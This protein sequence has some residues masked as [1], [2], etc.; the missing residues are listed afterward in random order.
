[1]TK[2]APFAIILF[3]A[4]VLFDH[5]Y[6]ENVGDYS[7][8]PQP[9]DNFLEADFRLV[10][11][12]DHAPPSAILVFIPGTDGDGRGIIT[13]STFLALSKACHAALMGCDYRGEGLSYEDPTGGSGRAL[14]EAISHFAV[15]THTPELAQAPLLL[16]GYSQGGIFTYNY[17]C[18][19]PERVR[20]FAALKAVIPKFQP[21]PES[22]RIPG[23]LIA[24]QMD[25]PERIRSISSAFAAAAGKHSEWALLFERGNGHELDQKSIGLT[26]TFFE[27]IFQP[28]KAVRPIFLNAESGISETAD[29]T[30]PG[31]CWFPNEDVAESWR[32]LHQPTSLS[33]L[34]TIPEWPQLQ[35]LISVKCD[36]E[37]YGCENGNQQLGILDL[38][39][40]TAGITIDHV[41]AFG[42]GFSV[43]STETDKLPMQIKLCFAPRQL[44]WGQI[45]A[46]IELDGSLSGKKLQPFSFSV[47]G[48]VKGPVTAIPSM[49]YLGIVSRGSN[50]AQK[51]LLKSSLSS[52]HIADIRT[53]EGMT[54]TVE[55]KG[56][57]DTQLEVHWLVG[58]RLGR[59]NAEIQLTLDSPEKGTLRIPVI[60]IVSR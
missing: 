20:A 44:P 38:I 29:S 47:L 31:V 19:Y 40:D 11:P 33:D 2:V 10:F 8:E 23:L 59:M 55:E 34:M 3:F 41:Q 18:S 26:Q 28:S 17:V 57:G 7:V 50:I 16:I 37:K 27:A 32:H 15:S 42:E 21:K 4:T 49:I 58:S 53:P 1:M 54:V 14:D 60:G 46:D 13:N 36:P 43:V 30:G 5:V 45:R 6:S 48:V 56:D 9:K 12:D 39:S 52:V 22:F 51:I 35:S 24:G 25:K